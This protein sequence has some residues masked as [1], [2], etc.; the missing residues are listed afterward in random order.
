MRVISALVIDIS[1]LCDFSVPPFTLRS[2]MHEQTH[3]PGSHFRLLA[4][5]GVR[6]FMVAR[7]IFP[8]RLYFGDIS[9]LDKTEAGQPVLDATPDFCNKQ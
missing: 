3:I 4:Y 9:N 1:Y 8:V 6:S 5:W 7:L 2:D